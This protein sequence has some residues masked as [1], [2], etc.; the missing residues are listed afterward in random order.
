METLSFA[1]GV[2]SMIGLLLVIAVVVGAL[3]VIKQQKQIKDLEQYVS[4]INQDVRRQIT[5]EGQYLHGRIDRMEDT[6]P[7]K[8][9]DQITDSVTQCNSYTD[10]RIDK[11]IDN[12]FVV[13]ETNKLIKG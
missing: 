12:Y 1:F 11:L 5:G 4:D 9:N 13:K 8:I 6:F 2:L 7:R 3:K 10:K